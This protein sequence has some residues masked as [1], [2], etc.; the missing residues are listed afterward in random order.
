VA[1]GRIA[2]RRDHLIAASLTSAVVVVVG[3]ASGLGLRPGG[4]VAAQPPPAADVTQ[5]ATPTTPSGQQPA[6]SNEMPS[7][8][9]LPPLPPLPADSRPAD[10]VPSGT[11][12]G[13]VDVPVDGTQPDPGSAPPPIGTAPPSPPPSTPVPPP[14]PPGT[15]LPACKPGVTQQVLDTVGGLPLLGTL[16]TGLGVTGPDGL[17]ATVLGYCR[18]PDGAS[19]LALVPA[20]AVPGAGLL[21]GG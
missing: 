18:T 20:P 3:Y 7:M 13:A 16:T 10:S 9:Q 2:L 6:P 15:D 1:L 21:G 8:G 17:G 14:P 19:Q 12:G 4:A 5:P 11:P